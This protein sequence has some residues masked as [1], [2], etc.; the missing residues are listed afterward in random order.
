MDIGKL[1]KSYLQDHVSMKHKQVIVDA[2]G[3]AAT[4]DTQRVLVEQVLLAET[5]SEDLVMRSMVHFAGMDM[6]PAQVRTKPVVNGDTVFAMISRFPIPW[7]YM[8]VQYC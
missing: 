8:T 7:L 6:E 2:L 4:M 5:P 1:L 3:A